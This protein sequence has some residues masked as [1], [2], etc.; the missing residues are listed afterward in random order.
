MNKILTRQLENTIEK[1]SKK[2]DRLRK[3][4]SS[5]FKLILFAS[6]E[7][8]NTVPPDVTDACNRFINSETEGLADLELN[9]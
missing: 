4:H 7:D 1:D 3:L 8:A 2:K 5:V 6:A 9:A